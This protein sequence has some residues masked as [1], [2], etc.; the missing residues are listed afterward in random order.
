M[1]YIYIYICLYTYTVGLSVNHSIHSILPI[2]TAHTH[3]SFTP[4]CSQMVIDDPTGAS[5]FEPWDAV[6]IPFTL[7]IH[8]DHAHRSFTPII[9]TFLFT[10]G[11]QRS[12]WRFDLQTV[13]RCRDSIHTSY[14]HRSY[15]LFTP[16]IHTDH[17]HRSFTP[18]SV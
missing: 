5:I 17:S 6:D 4:F 10:D 2:H 18:F 11:H 14:S 12:H 8:T 3:R 7:P 1:L 16:I 15:F 13:G 9:H